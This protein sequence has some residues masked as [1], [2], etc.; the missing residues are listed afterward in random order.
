MKSLFDLLI[1]LLFTF[2]GIPLLIAGLAFHLISII[3]IGGVS[4]YFGI[5]IL[6]RFFK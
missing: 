6:K 5:S 1:G 4:T 2:E 3:A